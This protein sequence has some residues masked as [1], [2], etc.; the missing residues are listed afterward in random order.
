MSDE[1]K[2][3]LIIIVVLFGV[4]A[5]AAA[6]SMYGDNRKSAFLTECVKTDSVLDCGRAW[7]ERAR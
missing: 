5:M 4:L 2:L 1:Y 6:I 7:S 3:V